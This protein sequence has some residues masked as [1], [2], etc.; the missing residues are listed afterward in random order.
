MRYVEISPGE[1]T[2]RDGDPPPLTPGAAR[3]SVRACGVCGTDLHLLHGTGVG[4][5]VT[6]PLRPGHEVAGIVAELAQDADAGFQVGDLVVLHPL[7]PCGQCSA[8]RADRE[9]HCASGRVLGIDA[10]GGMAEELVWPAS[11]MVA[12]RGIPPAEAA[13]LPDAVA[14]A[15]HAL[16]KAAPPPGG[17]LCVLGAGGVG[18]QVLQLARAL[19]PRIRLAA[20]V[21]SEATAA[22]I[23]ALGVTAVAGLEQGVEQLRREM[24]RF[25]AVV[26]FS[27][28]ADGPAQGLRLLGRGGRLV[29]GAVVDEPLAFSTPITVV[30][31][32]ELVILG[33][34]SSTLPEL[35]AVA[36]LAESGSIDLSASVT[37]RFSLQDA[38]AA[39]RTLEERPPGMVRVVIDIEA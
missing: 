7:D 38:A 32:R 28:A 11:R 29:L 1:T 13:L 3:V 2:I 34:Y 37:H 17:S 12:V 24:G 9:Q 8:C 26:D 27:G 5:R 21:R 36:R 19:D 4:E 15:Y 6:Y 16:L 22:R 35:R 31:A 30:I 23:A 33:A 18:T 10:P 39:F 25:D 20:V 14:T